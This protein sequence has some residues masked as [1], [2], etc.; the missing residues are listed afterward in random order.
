MAL[1]V[2]DPGLL[3]TIQDAGRPGYE[4]FGVPVGG[5]M[6]GFALQAANRLVGNLSG[7]AAIE[8][9][10]A[11]PPTLY[12]S[13]DILLAGGGAG[14]SLHVDGTP[15]PRWMA[16][17][18]R[19]GQTV[20][21]LPQGVSN[22]GILAA[23]GGIDTPPVLGS[24]ATY[25]RS[26]LGGLEGRV[27]RPADWLP[28]G[29]PAANWMRLAGSAL[30]PSMIPA[31]ATKVTLEVILGP[32][33]NAFTSEAVQILLASTYTISPTSDRMGYRLE[34]PRLEHAGGGASH[35]GS[36]GADILSEGI[37]VGS[38]QVPGSGQPVLLLSD[39][40]TTGGYTKIATVITVD[41]PLA[42]QCP[43][44]KGQM[45]FRAVDVAHAQA[46]LRQQAAQWP[47]AI[48]LEDRD[49]EGETWI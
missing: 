30:K 10:S 18:V 16:F 32:Q 33:Q 48:Q 28:V 23:A 19:A 5:A 20:N 39:R 4:R 38:I 36:G 2:A 3:T 17:W 12:T 11:A 7:A 40:Q 46:H 37:A 47:V 9:L 15:I 49:W 14:F 13:E 45:R 22:W 26:A 8:F 31:Y 35:T 42:A 6:D 21:I 1:V 44:G 41:L 24:R 25:L 27:L 34:G 29:S 43:F